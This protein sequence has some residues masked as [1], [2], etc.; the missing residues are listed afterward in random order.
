MEDQN[1]KRKLASGHFI[2]Y[3]G[4]GTYQL[5]GLD[6]TKGVRWAL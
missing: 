3:I 6:C 1:L 5:K 2:P 4:Y